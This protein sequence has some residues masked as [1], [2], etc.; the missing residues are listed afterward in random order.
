MTG[1]PHEVS[2][3]NFILVQVSY[4]MLLHQSVHGAMMACAYLPPISLSLKE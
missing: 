3:S 1:P 2:Y 4:L